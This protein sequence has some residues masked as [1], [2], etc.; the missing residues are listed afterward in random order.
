VFATLQLHEI[1]FAAEQFLCT[2]GAGGRASVPSRATALSS[3]SATHGLHPATAVVNEG[4]AR[5]QQQKK[6]TKETPGSQ[7]EWSC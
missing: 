4:E 3:M 1:A 7:P 2:S 6:I 5:Y